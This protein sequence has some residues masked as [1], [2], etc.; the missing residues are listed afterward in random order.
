MYVPGALLVSDWFD[1][2]KSLL[3]D[4]GTFTKCLS[5]IWC[6]WSV[7]KPPVARDDRTISTMGLTGM[8]ISTANMSAF[9]TLIREKVGSVGGDKTRG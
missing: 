9:R 1:A 3:G 4:I 5:N 2:T 8:S 7:H 6:A